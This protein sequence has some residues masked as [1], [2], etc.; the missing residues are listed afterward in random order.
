M[1]FRGMKYE[2]VEEEDIFG[3]FTILV[4]MGTHSERAWNMP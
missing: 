1:S 4:G 3:I 2:R